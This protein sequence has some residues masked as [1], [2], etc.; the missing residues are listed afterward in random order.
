MAIGRGLGWIF[1]QSLAREG[2]GW[3]ASAIVVQHVIYFYTDEQMY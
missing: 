2:G 1:P 3:D